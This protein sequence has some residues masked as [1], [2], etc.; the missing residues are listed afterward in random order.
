MAT[1]SSL[2][3]IIPGS[4]AN[5]IT[6]RATLKP[7]KID[8]D[9]RAKVGFTIYQATNTSSKVL[10]TVKYKEIGTSEVMKSSISK[11]VPLV[12][13]ARS[14]SSNNC[15]FENTVLNTEDFSLTFLFKLLVAPATIIS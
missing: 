10:G 12:A 4:T 8:I 11:S 6:D 2:G 9:I 14:G 13:F 7:S 15:N 3:N 5:S 1:I